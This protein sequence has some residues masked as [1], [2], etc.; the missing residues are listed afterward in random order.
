MTKPA[1]REV[2]A[3]K[4]ASE[5]ARE[6]APTMFPWSTID[7]MHAA[8]ATAI[9]QARREGAEDMRERARKAVCIHCAAGRPYDSGRN[10]HT[11]RSGGDILLPAGE[12]DARSIRAL[13][14]DGEA[15]R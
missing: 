14:L 12:C 6:L 7:E 4:P 13:L 3:M 15:G 10:W 5:V 8:I 1:P 2:I 11:P 9:Q